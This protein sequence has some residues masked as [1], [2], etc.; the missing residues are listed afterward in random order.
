MWP[1]CVDDTGVVLKPRVRESDPP[2]CPN[3]DKLCVSIVQ[4]VRLQNVDAQSVSVGQCIQ[5][6]QQQEAGGSIVTNFETAVAAWLRR[7]PVVWILA[8]VLLALVVSGV[9]V[10]GLRD[11]TQPLARQAQHL[12]MNRAQR[13]ALRDLNTTIQEMER[14]G[15]GSRNSELLARARAAR[16]AQA[17]QAASIKATARRAASALDVRAALAEKEGN[18][19]TAAVM[20]A[21]SRRVMADAA[22]AAAPFDPSFVF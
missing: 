17:A 21:D 1:P 19:E 14:S 12:A 18:A 3:I 5:A 2:L 16:D 7:N 4:N 8:L 13:R 15:S 10:L 22:E 20:R 6:A 9:L 11:T